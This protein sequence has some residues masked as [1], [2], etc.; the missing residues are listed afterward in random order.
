MSLMFKVNSVVWPWAQVQATNMTRYQ[1]VPPEKG[2]YLSWDADPA[3]T[4]TISW[5]SVS[6]CDTV[7]HYGLSPTTLAHTVSNDTGGR[8]HHVRLTGLTPDTRYYYQIDSTTP[9]I[10]TPEQ[11][12][13]SSFQTGL[14]AFAP[15]KFLVM[16]DNQLGGK[17]LGVSRAD[18]VCDA[19]AAL[20]LNTTSGDDAR[21][22]LT[23]GDQFQWRATRAYYLG[24]Y[25]RFFTQTRPLN[26]YV[27]FMMALG[28][29]DRGSL[30]TYRDYVA[31]P[32]DGYAPELDYAFEFGDC[33]YLVLNVSRVKRPISAGHLAWIAARLQEAQASRW[34]FVNFHIPYY[35]SQVP[36]GWE[37]YGRYLD[38]LFHQYGVDMVFT[39]HQH[40][41]E[42]MLIPDPTGAGPGI[43][44][45]QNGGGGGRLN[46]IHTLQNYTSASM[47]RQYHYLRVNVGA[48]QVSVRCVS[49]AGR[50]LD[51]VTIRGDTP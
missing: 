17:H 2:P 38:P 26:R 6:S 10:L 25:Q 4:M 15:F 51:V 35:V 9:G 40:Y 33:Y 29:H 30:E 13:V 46:G 20:E 19:A 14:A 43:H 23:G 1:D 11:L 5:E 39:G 45:F 3:T 47:N 48:D 50:V 44:Y 41:Y 21:F 37:T 36:Q 22:V 28:N 49:Q 42:H 24:D 31:L 16:S 27:P 18:W 12:R 8:L 32:G 7:V 34:I